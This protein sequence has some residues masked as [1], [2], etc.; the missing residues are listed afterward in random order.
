MARMKPRLA[1][2]TPVAPIPV[3]GS[4]EQRKQDVRVRDWNAHVT[5]MKQKAQWDFDA[6]VEGWH[7]P[8]PDSKLPLGWPDNITPPPK[9]QEEYEQR[10]AEWRSVQKP[11]YLKCFDARMAANRRRESKSAGEPESHDHEVIT[12]TVTAHVTAAL[13]KRARR[14]EIAHASGQLA[15]ARG[16][17][18][19]NR[20]RAA[21]SP[22]LEGARVHNDQAAM[23]E[24]R[25][26][27]R[28]AELA[29]LRA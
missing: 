23:W 22:T 2:Y 15:F 3:A 29:A 13:D 18:R 7:T 19:V 21:A 27:L 17:V 28:E 25:V 5:R 10:M 26:P 20:E 14:E 11:A 1:N 6:E 8:D 16:R 12:V 24:A 4:K 9:D